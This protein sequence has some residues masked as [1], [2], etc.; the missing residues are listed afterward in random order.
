MASTSMVLLPCSRVTRRRS[1]ERRRGVSGSCTPPGIMRPTRGVQAVNR[2]TDPRVVADQ[3]RTILELP[4]AAYRRAPIRLELA[5]QWHSVPDQIK[6]SVGGFPGSKRT[7][8]DVADR[9]IRDGVVPDSDYPSID[10]DTL[11]KPSAKPKRMRPSWKRAAE[12]LEWIEDE[13]PGLSPTGEGRWYCRDQWEYIKEYGCPAY[14]PQHE[15]PS[16]LTWCRYLKQY[17]A[18][19]RNRAGKK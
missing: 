5:N 6:N 3:I 16:F 17:V 13:R 11:T 12:S 9:C 7:W 18:Y 10:I 2:Q 14:G 19:N 1:G 15:T 8:A 4:D